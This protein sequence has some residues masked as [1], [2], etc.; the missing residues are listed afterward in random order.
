MLGYPLGLVEI[1][2]NWPICRGGCV[3]RILSEEIQDTHNILL[4]IQNFPGNSGSPVIVKPEN[5]SLW[6]TK[7]IKSSMLIGVIHSYYPY[8][9]TAINIQTGERVEIRCE[10]SGIANAH[11]VEFIREV[12][13][14]EKRR[15]IS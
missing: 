15:I 5:S 7:P 10:N 2:S 9:E 3:D 12:L 11:P 6:G 8:R 1:D 14:I 13:E 4:D